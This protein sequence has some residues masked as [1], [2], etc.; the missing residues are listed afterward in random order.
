MHYFLFRNDTRSALALLTV[1]ASLLLAL[2]GALPVYAGGIVTNCSN[3]TD[4]KAKLAGGGLVTFNCNGN[5]SPATILV[6]ASGGI[7]LPSGGTTLNGGSL[8]TLSGGTTS[9]VFST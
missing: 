5:G 6:V 3:D 4:L 7:A 2:C 9:I 1:L 8:I